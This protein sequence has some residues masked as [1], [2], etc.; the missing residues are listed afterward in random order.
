MNVLLISNSDN[1]GGSA[2]ASHRL[3]VGLKRLGVCSRMLVAH[4]TLP[5]EDIHI[6]ASGV[7]REMDQL[8]GRTTNRVSLQYLFYPSTFL[9]PWRRWFHEADIVQLCNSHGGY[10]THTALPLLSRQ[11]AVVWRLDDMWPLTGHCPFP[12]EC[13]RWRNGCGRCPKLSE[14]P[15][16]RRDTTRL[17]W[18]I[19]R[20]AYGNST[21]ILVAPTEWM[22][23]QIRESPLTRHLRVHVIPYGLDTRV[24][25]RSSKEDARR[26]LGLNGKGPILLF[27]AYS[28]RDPRKGGSYLEQALHRLASA[29]VEEATVLVVGRWSEELKVPGAFARRCLE[30]VESDEEMANIYAAADLLVAPSLAESFGQVF[31]EAMACGTPSVAFDNTAVREVVRHMETGYL[32]VSEDSADLAEGIRLLSTNP[33][34]YS[35]MSD[36]GRKMVEREFTLGLQARRY[37]DLYQELLADGW[38]RRDRSSCAR[39]AS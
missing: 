2:R 30:Y 9:L 31:S 7:L 21:L 22:A 16:L 18:K 14:Y 8:C 26:K 33:D 6:L 29:G 3:H 38:V 12:F 28:I 1:I 11:K 19:K 32:A 13:E 36:C 27:T 15:R 24:F 10:F 17:L 23:R 20:A 5:D 39:S 37:H 4:K 25:R 34:L 35:R